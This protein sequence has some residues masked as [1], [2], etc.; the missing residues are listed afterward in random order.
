MQE[1]AQAASEICSM[2]STGCSCLVPYLFFRMESGTVALSPRFFA[3]ELKAYSDWRDAFW[4]ELVQNSVDAGCRNIDV[5]IAGSEDEPS[6]TFRD[7]G[8][9]MSRE[10]LRDVYFQLGATTKGCLLYTSPSPRD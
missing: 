4:R 5:R 7:D 2:M 1:T 9:G 8:P 6:V 3:N 10:T